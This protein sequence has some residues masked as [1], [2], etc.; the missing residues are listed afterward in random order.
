MNAAGWWLK[1]GVASMVVLLA[2]SEMAV[3]R[4]AS[5]DSPMAASCAAPAYRQF[6]FWVGDWNAFDVGSP[7]KV[8]HARVDRI[9]DG[10]VLR[11]DYQGADG[12]KGQSFTIYDAARKVWHQSWV[13]N[14]GELLVIEGKS[15][16]DEMVLTGEDHAKGTIVRGVW[17]PENGGVR[18]T[19]DTSSDG[20]KTWKPWFDLVFRPNAADNANAS[21]GNAPANDA[22]V[23]DKSNDEK[24]VAAL[25]TEYQA[26]VKRND[27]DTMDRILADDFV[28]VTGS[29]KT[30][31]KADLLNE[32]R[33]VRAV[34]ERQEDSE[35]KVRVW[36]DIAVVTAKLW[37][38][39]TEGGKSFEYSLWFS[40]TYLRTPTGWRYTFAQS[41][42]R[43]PT[44]P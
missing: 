6:D 33:T 19:A 30:Y 20:G 31:T 3:A 2:T 24:I 40:D 17:K 36:G 9:L 34:Y 28:L 15:E 25:D 14:R 37:V 10:C 11:E 42:L 12:H 38:K 23:N 35:Q 4:V 13:T 41:S 8:A 26:A 7:N 27:A 16:G 1:V 22:S 39:G 21:T 32:A 18:E 5:T 44:N 43:L 29:G